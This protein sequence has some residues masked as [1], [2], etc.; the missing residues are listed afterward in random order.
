MSR[1]LLAG[2]AL[3]AVIFFS[4]WLYRSSQKK[5]GQD[6]VPEDTAAVYKEQKAKEEKLPEDLKEKLLLLQGILSGGQ[7]KM[8]DYS[9]LGEKADLAKSDALVKRLLAL[10]IDKQRPAVD[11]ILS[12]IKEIGYPALKPITDM[13]KTNLLENQQILLLMALEQIEDARITGQLKK[14]ML[15]SSS[16]KVRAKSCEM[17]LARAAR[18]E[19]NSFLDESRAALLK[20]DSRDSPAQKFNRIDALGSIGGAQAFDILKN[21]LQT[22]TEY[23]MKMQSIMAIGKIKSPE[24]MEFLFDIVRNEPL[25]RNTAASALGGFPSDYTT[26]KAIDIIEETNDRALRGAALNILARQNTPEARSYLLKLIEVSDDFS[27]INEAAL[28]ASKLQSPETIRSLASLLT[29]TDDV[30]RI[31]SI[32][33]ALAQM[34]E[35]SVPYLEEAALKNTGPARSEAVRTL[36]QINSPKAYDALRTILDNAI[37]GD[38]TD[39]QREALQGLKNSRKEEMAPVIERLAMESQ[40][41]DIRRTAM[42]TVVTLKKK[43]QLAFITRVYEQDD[44]DLVKRAALRMMRRYGNEQTVSFLRR[45]ILYGSNP[46][47]RD[48]IERTIEDIERR[49]K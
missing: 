49:Q 10:D 7:E 15:T 13:L 17:F 33:R 23:K 46:A 21:I 30:N 43:D 37:S 25:L 2:I 45:E 32:G 40:N 47:L 14:L 5:E 35:A 44:S 42:E 31:R 20:G 9:A 41:P 48:D 26:R 1:K 12:Q 19:I 18:D 29:S 6:I 36:S 24:S 34:G 3:S 11:S 27:I 39:T 4:I 8:G 16:E 22:S 38:D 28:A